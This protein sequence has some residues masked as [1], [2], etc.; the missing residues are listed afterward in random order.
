MERDGFLIL[1][2]I[3][4][5]QE[6]SWQIIKNGFIQGTGWALGATFGLGLVLFI[7]SYIVRLLGGLPVIGQLLAAIVDLT[8]KALEVKQAL[9]Q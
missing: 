7:I 1:R 5:K 2:G 3:V 4:V 6:S 8:Q 9:D